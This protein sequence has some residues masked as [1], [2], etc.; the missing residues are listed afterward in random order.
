MSHVRPLITLDNKDEI[1]FYAK[2]IVEKGLS[3]RDVEKLMR[4]D[5]EPVVRS[6]KPK[7]DAH[8]VDV[9]RSV[10]TRL[11]TKVKINPKNI[12]ISYSDTDDLNRL[13]E[14]MGLLED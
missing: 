9:E 12:Q 13:L 3:V 5:K 8:L 4:L 6:K 2:E 11:S 7:V 10:S 1:E 14:I